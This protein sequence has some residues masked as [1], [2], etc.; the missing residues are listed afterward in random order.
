MT[1]AVVAVASWVPR[2][3]RHLRCHGLPLCHGLWHL[4]CPLPWV[5]RARCRLLVVLLRAARALLL[6]L[7]VARVVR[8]RAARCWDG[9][10]PTSCRCRRQEVPRVVAV[11]S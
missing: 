5:P 4:C 10:P 7:A 8:P 3:L 2:A 1:A 11:A 6:G 9:T